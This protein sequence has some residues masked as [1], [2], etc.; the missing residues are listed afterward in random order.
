MPENVDTLIFVDVDGVLNVGIRDGARAP[1]VLNDANVAV[2]QGCKDGAFSIVRYDS[3]S[4]V[5]SAAHMFS[6]LVCEGASQC[7]EV[8]VKR[9][10]DIL[11]SAS[12]RSSVVLSSNWRKAKFNSAVEELQED[13]SRHL[14]EAFIFDDRTEVVSEIRARDR[15]RSIGAFVKRHYSQ[16]GRSAPLRV[17]IIDDFF[18][19]GLS[20]WACDGVCMHGEEDFQTYL[21]QCAPFADLRVKLVHC[22]QEWRTAEGVPVQA[23][24]G[25]SDDDVQVA[26]A[27]L[28]MEFPR[29]WSWSDLSTIKSDMVRRSSKFVADR[30][31]MVDVSSP[32][33][34][35]QTA[36]SPA[37]CWTGVLSLLRVV[38]LQ[39]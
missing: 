28:Q 37:L 18:A 4:K 24:V 9:L 2:A 15:L 27:F 19:T 6:D 10:A 8:L 14:G 17:L 21:Q 12:G 34:E 7:S 25:L 13:I 3:V 5:S 30:L 29:V 23:G 11:A 20:G 22:Y 35:K 1:L 39:M 16:P 38:C 31:V 33:G 36:T 32:M 26:R